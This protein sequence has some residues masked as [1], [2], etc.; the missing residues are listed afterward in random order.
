VL[1]VEA[2]QGTITRQYNQITY[3]VC[4]I[5]IQ[6]FAE[7]STLCRVHF[8]VYLANHY[9]PS[10]TLT[11]IT[12]SATTSFIKRETLGI[13]R[14]SAKGGFTECQTLGETDARQRAIDSRL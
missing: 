13:D 6:L 10:A 7:C 12:L 4:T 2:L 1:P 14:Y 8:V 9:L 5:G 3:L 11:E